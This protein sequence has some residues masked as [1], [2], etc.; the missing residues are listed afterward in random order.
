MKKLFILVLKNDRNNE[1][2]IILQFQPK[3]FFRILS[4]FP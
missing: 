4:E 1:E 2:I 3:D